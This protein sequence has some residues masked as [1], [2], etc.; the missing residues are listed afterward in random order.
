MYAYIIDHID[1]ID[2]A[3]E[4][5]LASSKKFRTKSEA[6]ENLDGTG[7]KATPTGR[8][9]LHRGGKIYLI[10]IVDLRGREQRDRYETVR[11]TMASWA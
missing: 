7:Y 5:E 9:S 4:R 1:T 6:V 11:D 8:F 3:F 2:C 10:E